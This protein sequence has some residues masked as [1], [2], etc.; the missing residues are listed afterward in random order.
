[1]NI[2]A[3]ISNLKFCA[4]VMLLGTAFGS[5][6]SV[7]NMPSED[8]SVE[9][10]VNFKYEK[11]MKFADAFAHEVKSVT[12]YAFDNDGKFIFSKSEQGEHLAQSGYTMSMPVSLK[13]LHLITWAGLDNGESFTVPTLVPGVST[14]NE[15]KCSLKRDYV[16]NKAV[17]ATDLHHLFHGENHPQIT[18]R[19]PYSETTTVALT[20]NT[21]NVRVVLQ[22][23]SDQPLDANEFSFRIEDENGLMDYDNKVLNDETITYK[24]WFK[25]GGTADVDGNNSHIN[26]VLAEFTIAR[27]A[28]QNAPRLIVTNSNNE[29]VISVPIIDYALLVK[30]NYNHEMDDQEYLDRQD[31][32]NMTFFL[33]SNKQWISSSIIIN[34]WKVVL[35]DLDIK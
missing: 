3:Y 8:C 33:D 7:L 26:M 15:L 24:P 23:L 22:Q 31:E 18:S 17:V 4:I 9:Y 12:V 2:S 16:D 20:K 10:L 27:L 32:Y 5:C 1:M 28:T 21:N 19:V 34:G 25:K 6:D 30:G 14:I 11:N 29:S 13:N 35:N